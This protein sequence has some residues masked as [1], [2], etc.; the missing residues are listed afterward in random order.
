V[1]EKL[2]KQDIKDVLEENYYTL[3]STGSEAA[4]AIIDDFA[5]GNFLENLTDWGVDAVEFITAYNEMVDEW[6]AQ[7]KMDIP[8]MEWGK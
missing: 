4:Y 6:C 7:G 1:S 5:N 8:A 3:A 2:S